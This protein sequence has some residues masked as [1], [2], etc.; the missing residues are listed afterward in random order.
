MGG[1]DAAVLEALY[2]SDLAKEVIVFV[3]K[4]S[5]KAVEKK[6]LETLLAR[7]NVKI[8]YN[9]EVASIQGDGE[10][11]TGVLLKSKKGIALDGLFL[12]IGSKPNSALFK[13]ALKLDPSG[14]IVLNKD[15]QTSI[16]GVYAIGDIVAMELKRRFKPNN[17]LEIMDSLQNLPPLLQRILK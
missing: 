16:E 1:G 14:Y 4:G 11:V 7:P 2:L 3:R 8:F 13:N 12:A 15:Q 5:F 17:F 10:K 6:R 9:T